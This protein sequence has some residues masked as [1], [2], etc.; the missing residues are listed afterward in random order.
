MDQKDKVAIFL[1][2]PCGLGYIAC[3]IL[4]GCEFPPAFVAGAAVFTD[5]GTFATV[6]GATTPL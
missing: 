5:A 2:A 6:V 1:C 3:C 4:C